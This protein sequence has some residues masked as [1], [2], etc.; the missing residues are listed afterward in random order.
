MS[1]LRVLAVTAAASL[2]AL[3][4]AVPASAGVRPHVPS[5]LALGSTGGPAVPVGDVVAA[6]LKAGTTFTFGPVTCTA[7]ALN[8]TDT[9]N[10]AAPGVA[11]LD[12]TAMPVGGCSGGAT[13]TAPN[14]PLPLRITSPTKA[15]LAPSG[16]PFQL[17]ITLP[18]PVFTCVYATGSGGL[19]GSVSNT[20]N[21]MHFS[22]TLTKAAGS[23]VCPASAALNVTFAPMTDAGTTVFVN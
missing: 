5:V 10:P 16:P 3:A 15:V 8:A 13:V 7:A 14:L 21:D 2:G 17:A 9:T 4:L 12:V 11:L 1:R 18:S 19:Q 23:S 22:Q 6:P 20:D